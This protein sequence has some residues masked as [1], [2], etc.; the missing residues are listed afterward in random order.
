VTAA[1]FD[2]QVL[3]AG[4]E[5]RHLRKPRGA[6]NTSGNAGRKRKHQVAA[7]AWKPEYDGRVPQEVFH[8]PFNIY[9]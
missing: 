1:A 2:R 3:V 7:T 6:C 4:R 5:S 9:F 8:A